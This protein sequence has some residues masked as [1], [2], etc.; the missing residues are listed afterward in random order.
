MYDDNEIIKQFVLGTMFGLATVLLMQTV[1]GKPNVQRSQT[2]R[3]PDKIEPDTGPW[4]AVEVARE[5]RAV[6]LIACLATE[7]QFSQED[8]RFKL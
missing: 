1:L 4:G 2:R 5:A 6:Q 3:L 7:M 8:D